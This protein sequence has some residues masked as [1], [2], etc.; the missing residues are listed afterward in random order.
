MRKESHSCSNLGGKR[1]SIQGDQVIK[2]KL[3]SIIKAVKHVRN[4]GRAYL[5]YVIDTN[6]GVP[7]LEDVNVVN[8]Y[9]DVFPEDLPG[10]P[11]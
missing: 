10:A 5:S 8:E 6:R 3:C 11:T 4:G 7:K 2:S 1:V 9:P